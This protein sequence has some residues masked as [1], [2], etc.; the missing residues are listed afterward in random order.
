MQFSK[1]TIALAAAVMYAAA[2][3]AACD[4]VKCDQTCGK[5]GNKGT[6]CGSVLCNDFSKGTIT[7]CDNPTCDQ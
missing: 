3:S 7:C 1:I 4:R 5:N 2:V 6:F